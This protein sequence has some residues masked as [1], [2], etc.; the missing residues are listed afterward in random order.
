MMNIRHHFNKHK[1]MQEKKKLEE[2]YK[3]QIELLK[4]L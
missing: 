3:N 2:Y 1:M 4:V